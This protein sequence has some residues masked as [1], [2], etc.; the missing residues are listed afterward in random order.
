MDRSW[1][2]NLACAPV[3]PLHQ[4]KWNPAYALGTQW[5][6]KLAIVTITIFEQT[7][8]R[9]VSY[10]VKS[11]QEQTYATKRWH[12]ID[13]KWLVRVSLKYFIIA[14]GVILMKL[15]RQSQF[16]FSHSGVL[17]SFM[18]IIIKKQQQQRTENRPYNNLWYEFV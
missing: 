7:I 15:N 8:S 14:Y 1:L 17:K 3:L 16:L 9:R 6:S 12:A 2:Q 13:A 5:L 11:L 18:S 4:R 10:N